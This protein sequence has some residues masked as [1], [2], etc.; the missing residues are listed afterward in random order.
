M[1]SVGF[2]PPLLTTHSG[3][4]R[5]LPVLTEFQNCSIAV[6]VTF[7]ETFGITTGDVFVMVVS[8]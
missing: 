5:V 8:C 7:K 1:D 2:R 4:L 3:K 6:Q